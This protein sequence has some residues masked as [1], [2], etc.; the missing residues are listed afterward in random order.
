MSA[1]GSILIIDDEAEIRESLE[2]LLKLEGYQADSAPTS[3]EGLKGIEIG[4]F[5]LVL[6]DINLP[7]RNGLDLLQQIKAVTV[8]QID[9]EQHQVEDADFN[10]LQ[11]FVAG[12]GGVRLIAFEFQK[13]LEAF[14]YFCFVVNDEDR[15]FS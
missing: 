15:A 12:R 7:D 13:L 11:T 8:R 1:K 9:V 5:D 6:L 3:D 10:A 4:V 2:Q 14:A